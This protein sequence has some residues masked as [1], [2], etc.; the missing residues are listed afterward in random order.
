VRRLFEDP[1][2]VEEAYY[3]ATGIF[4]IMHTVVLRRELYERSPWVARSLVKAF[5]VARDLAYAR[6]AETAALSYMAPWLPVDTERTVALMGE[7]FWPYGLELN[8]HV[9]D[10]FLRYHHEQG[11][12]PRRLRPEELFAAE[13]LEAFAI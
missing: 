6:L 10:T 9:L 1:R 11:L 3:A 4:P 2:T 12:S 5:T 8:R 13:T 7:D